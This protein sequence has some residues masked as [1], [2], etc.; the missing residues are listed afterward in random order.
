[1]RPIGYVYV[2][3]NPSMPGLVKVGMTDKH[4]TR[5]RIAELSAHTGV[6]EHFRMEYRAQV[7]E[8][9]QVE[10]RTHAFLA[11]RFQKKKE[12]FCCDIIHAVLAI[13]ESAGRDLIDQEIHCELGSTAGNDGDLRA[14]SL[15]VTCSIPRGKAI[16]GV[17]RKPLEGLSPEAQIVAAWKVSSASVLGHVFYGNDFLTA[18]KVL[19]AA[20]KDFPHWRKFDSAVLLETPAAMRVRD[21]QK[22]QE[23][24]D[25]ENEAMFGKRS[26][27]TCSFSG[28]Y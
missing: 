15:E 16:T 22:I 27:R 24:C 25:R 18:R 19:T 23:E 7:W 4:N 14:A 9:F 5:S 17:T 10:Q 8:A 13:R 3:T 2:A 21:Y 6:P 1:M 20:C 12:F 28:P 11:Q 26:K